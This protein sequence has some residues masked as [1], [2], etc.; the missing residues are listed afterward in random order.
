MR[1]AIPF[2][3]FWLGY[4][5][6]AWFV[7]PITFEVPSLVGLALTEA[8][9][10]AADK[11]MTLRL[12]E[13]REDSSVPAGTILFQSPVAGKKAK[14]NHSIHVVVACHPQ[15]LIMPDLYGKKSHDIEQIM[16][17]Q[18][19]KVQIVLMPFSGSVQDTCYAQHPSPGTVI[20]SESVV[21]Y[22][23]KAAEIQ[24]IVPDMKGRLLGEVCDFLLKHGIDYQL[25]GS[26]QIDAIVVEQM[27]KPGVGVLAST[28]PR[29]YIKS[30]CNK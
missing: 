29:F 15:P 17:A 21:V 20:G 19:C 2:V 23:A 9:V 10:Q 13:E 30:E 5:V 8:L 28:F 24:C 14:S 11:K 22:C 7:R 12:L 25:Y 4:G 27:P 6:V 1:W 18:G 3:V 26:T 16:K